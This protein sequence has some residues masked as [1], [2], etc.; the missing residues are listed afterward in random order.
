[1]DNKRKN[2]LSDEGKKSA[3]SKAHS[4]EEKAYSQEKSAYGHGKT[5]YLEERGKAR[6]KSRMGKL[7]AVLF[8]AMY[9]PSL[10]YWFYG[11]TVTTDIMRMGKIENSINADALLVRD[12]VVLEAPFDGE[13]IPHMEEGEKVPASFPVATVVSAS[14]IKLLKDMNDINAKILAARK[15][16]EK[17]G[18]LFGADIQKIEDEIGRKVNLL[19]VEVNS[20]RLNRVKQI[21]S[22]IDR[23]IDKKFEILG[24]GEDENVYIKALKEE[25]KK[26]MKSMEA[27]M[28]EIKTE[29]PGIVSYVVDG[30]ENILNP[31][32][33][34]Q[35]TPEIIEN[36]LGEKMRV[37]DIGEREVKSNEPFAKVIKDFK[38]YVVACL[39]QG[40]DASWT[41]G[42]RVLL[43]IND[44]NRTMSGIVEFISGE[45]DGKRVMAIS[46]DRYLGE[47]SG[48]RRINVDLIKSSHEGLIVPMKSLRNI[49]IAGA[50][51]KKAE[52]IILKGNVASVREVII[53]SDNG[54]YAIIEPAN[55]SK[56]VYLYDTYVLN[57]E[58][59]QDEQVI[60][61]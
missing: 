59:I 40:Q 49:R 15:S 52:I 32:S 20:N 28:V 12:V 46:V 36:I 43:R 27:C 7:L 39:K 10:F 54:D 14:S 45:Q 48:L 3:K 23:L 22:E 5:Y 33:I 13:Y 30:Y 19:A 57:P 21:K 37:L 56:G 38:Y 24:S 47:M 42:D 2:Y 4:H 29:S 55:K 26:I 44:I 17:A 1:M 18:E 53:V 16:M 50:D 51:L 6:K 11:N 60:N 34:E 8:V 31:R 41:K 35:L 58:N 61:K 9:L 25:K